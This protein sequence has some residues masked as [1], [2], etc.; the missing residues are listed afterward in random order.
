MS[1]DSTP[2]M[3]LEPQPDG[4][5]RICSDSPWEAMAGYARAVIDGDWVLVSGTVGVEADGSFAPSAQRQAQRALD[6]I[7]AALVAAGSGL[8]DVR[9]VR[10]YVPDPGDVPVVSQV[11]K[12]RLGA[13]RPANTTICSPLAVQHARVELEVT[14]RRRAA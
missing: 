11:L 10:V 9:R 4:S 13:V 12:E 5:L 6:I 7:A 2:V 14:A 8:G 1:A 3:N